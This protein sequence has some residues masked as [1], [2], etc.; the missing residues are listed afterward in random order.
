MYFPYPEVA[1]TQPQ[2]SAEGCISGMDKS[3]GRPYCW[4]CN[5]DDHDQMFTIPTINKGVLEAAH[6]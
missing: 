1:D 3:T 6:C 2:P 4:S 5:A